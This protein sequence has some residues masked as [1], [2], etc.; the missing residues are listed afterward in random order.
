MKKI[1]YLFTVLVGLSACG[2]F[3]E[4]NTNP[5]APVQVP[6]E[7]LATQTIIDLSYCNGGGSYFNDSW[8]MKTS[9]FTERSQDYLYNKFTRASFDSYTQMTE[10]QKMEETAFENPRYS[11]GQR[12]AYRALNLFA[13]SFWYYEMTMSMGDI[14]CLDALNGESGNFSPK[15]DPQEQVFG[16]IINRLAEASTLFSEAEAFN[17]DPVF[18][19]DVK[20]WERTVNCFMLRV[21][22]MLS[23]HPTVDGKNVRELFESYASKPL[24]ETEDD[25]FMRVFSSSKSTEKHPFFED[26]NKFGIFPILSDFLIKK[27]KDN[28]DPRLFYYGE[29]TPKAVAAGLAPNDPNAYAGPN[30][31]EAYAVISQ[32]AT[33]GEYS[34]ENLRYWKHPSGEPYKVVSYS[35]TEF[36]FAEAALRG[37][38]TPS[39]AKVHYEN[40]VRATMRF[41]AKNTPDQYNHGVSITDNDIDTYLSGPA[42]F[43]GT[44]TSAE[45][46]AQIMDQKL[47]GSFLQLRWNSY[48]D[49]RRTG[50]PVIPIDPKTT[51]NDVPDRIP[52]RWMYPEDEY[53]Q[54]GANL[55]EALSRQFSGM[56]DVNKDMWLTK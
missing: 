5:D 51:Q 20:K 1:I 7:F 35:D 48:F 44:G 38:R 18:S 49:Y 53:S 4:I 17:G 23:A 10:G 28:N 3:T 32:N 12:K 16:E 47:L 34:A 22:N 42:A 56:D 6:A 46:L 2:D 45:Q 33:K 8:L 41:T 31:V 37:W 52:V 15:Y 29:P 50:Y 30:P 25:S 14:P 26:N 43:K 40:A 13:Q 19:G 24:I 27:L 21:L 55:Q 9:S 54:N 11:E 39:G 36:I